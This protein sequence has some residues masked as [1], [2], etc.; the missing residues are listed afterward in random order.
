M[1]HFKSCRKTGFESFC[2]TWY[3]AL[4]G[5][6]PF[7][8]FNPLFSFGEILV[9][10]VFRYDRS[11]LSLCVLAGLCGGAVYVH[12]FKLLA[13][14]VPAERR[15]LAMASASVAADLGIIFGSTAGIYIQACI[16][17]VQ[18]VSGAEVSG[19]YCKGR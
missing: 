9:C 17:E 14:H 3:L 1:W 8:H 7:V 6:G 19:A 12:G 18:D 2:G 11:L 13:A 15:E 4:Q 5:F 16:N 10:D